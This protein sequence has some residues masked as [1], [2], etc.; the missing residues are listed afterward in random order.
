MR[1]KE[2][3]AMIL[4]GGQGSRLGVLTDTL[5]KPAVPFGGKY[6]LI[7]FSLSNCFHSDI[8]TVGVLTQY[9][10]LELHRYI[11]I[12]SPWDLDRNAGGVF[13][14]PPF[15]QTRGGG[16]YKGTAN[17]IHQN[18]F[19]IDQYSPQYVLVLSGDHI[20]K[21]DYSL[22]LKF[23]KEAKA[24]ATIAVIAVPLKEASRFGVVNAGPDGRVVK[25]E[26]KPREPKS[27]LASMGV[28]LFTWDVLKTYLQQDDQDRDSAHDFGKNVLPAMLKDGL[29]MMAYRFEGYWKDVGTIESLWEANMDLLSDA[30]QLDLYDAGWRIFSVNPTS[31][32]HLVAPS[33]KVK[34]SLVSVGCLIFGEVDHS[35]LF[36]GVEIGHGAIIKDSV[37]MN[38]AKIGAGAYLEKAIVG[39]KAVIEENCQIGTVTARPGSEAKISVVGPQVTIPASTVVPAGAIVDQTSVLLQTT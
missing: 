35:V 30:P 37:V 6:R 4:A 9:R 32:P 3:V 21:M 18:A 28:Y 20:Y 24:D 13:I 15:V 36:A 26:E 17:A 2:W 34:C 22:L 33:G 10:P 31:P 16:W 39:P 25:F 5:A 7:D 14:L 1:G 27:N 11:G 12:G 19:F 8:D 23:H 29:K 38:E